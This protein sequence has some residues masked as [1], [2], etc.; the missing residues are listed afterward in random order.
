MTNIWPTV[1]VER[2]ALIEDLTHITP[3]QWAAPSLCAEWD[4][5]DVVAHLVA[6]AKVTHWK[7][8]KHF[9]AAG[10][11]FDRANANE[12]ADERR[13]DPADTLAAFRAVQFRTSSPPAPK[14]TRL[15]E[16]FLHGEDIR[17]P[18]GIAR[19]YPTTDVV[20]A[21][22][23]QARTKVG[24]G[25]GKERVAGL[26]LTATDTDF[27]LGNGPLVRGPAISLLLAVSG[28]RVA[29]ADL[30]GPGATVLA[31]R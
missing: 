31:D 17:R 2:Q 30:E 25:G 15:V 13:S 9:I 20:R 7:F 29:L 19:D 5:H 1:H 6:T 22:R 26:N 27:T 18:L 21:L 3:K 11:D 24:L 28:R 23:L 12:V 16:A 14:D 10:F 4:V 8:T